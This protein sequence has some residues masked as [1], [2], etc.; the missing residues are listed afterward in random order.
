[1]RLFISLAKYAVDVNDSN[2]IFWVNRSK[3]SLLLPRVVKVYEQLDIS[4]ILAQ[5]QSFTGFLY[6]VLVTGRTQR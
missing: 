3:R 2:F 1:M 5:L 6:F 4:L